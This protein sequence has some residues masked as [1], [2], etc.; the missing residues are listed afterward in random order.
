MANEQ[1][2][3]DRILALIGSVDNKS[4]ISHYKIVMDNDAQEILEDDDYSELVLKARVTTQT[5]SDGAPVVKYFFRDDNN[6]VEFEF[7][8]GQTYHIAYDWYSGQLY[9]FY[10]GVWYWAKEQGPIRYLFLDPRE[11]T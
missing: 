11:P 8:K 7:E 3:K 4:S 6:H 9:W 1:N 2:Q 5:W 10:G